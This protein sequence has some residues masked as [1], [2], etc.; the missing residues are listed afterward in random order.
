MPRLLLRRG[1]DEAASESESRSE[2]AGPRSRGWSRSCGGAAASAALRRRSARA[3]VR[4]RRTRTQSC[5]RRGPTWTRSWR[6]CPPPG[7]RPLPPARGPLPARH[8]LPLAASR[9]SVASLPCAAA[10]VSHGSANQSPPPFD[11]AGAAGSTCGERAARLT[12]RLPWS[13]PG[14]KFCRQGVTAPRERQR[15]ALW[16]VP[17]CRRELGIGAYPRGLRA[18]FADRCRARTG[19]DA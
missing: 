6:R 7:R 14:P 5:G 3:C 4:W 10:S 15:R 2:S 11:R 13:P 9:A 19:R 16:S 17:A 1:G 12:P 18:W 8:P